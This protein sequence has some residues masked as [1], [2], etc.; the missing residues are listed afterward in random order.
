MA[1]YQYR[2]EQRVDFEAENDE[3]AIRLVETFDLS[4][5]DDMSDD[6]RELE[7]LSDEPCSGK[8][9]D[10]CTKRTANTEDD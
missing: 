2:R 1:L 7:R 8:C 10:Q 9:G 3:E 4:S 6:G 5:T